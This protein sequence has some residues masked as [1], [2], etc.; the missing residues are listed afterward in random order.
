LIIAERLVPAV[1]RAWPLSLLLA[2]LLAVP[3]AALAAPYEGPGQS[4]IIPLGD[5]GH[6]ATL[7]PDAGL[8][9]THVA[10]DGLPADTCALDVGPPADGPAVAAHWSIGNRT[11]YVFAE[12]GARDAQFLIAAHWVWD[13]KGDC[14]VEHTPEGVI[15]HDPRGRP[16]IDLKFP[17]RRLTFTPTTGEWSRIEV[18]IVNNGTLPEH[19]D[20]TLGLRRAHWEIANATPAANVPIAPGATYVFG[21]DLLVPLEQ[22][23]RISLLLVDLAGRESGTADRATLVLD[24]QE[25]EKP[26]VVARPPPPALPPWEEPEEAP[27]SGVIALLVLVLGC[28]AVRRRVSG[29]APHRHGPGRAS[30]R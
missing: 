5:G 15:Y 20:I 28:L 11:A 8:G 25:G 1:L 23:A 27:G 3:P 10:L 19:A 13:V 14:T 2:T 18:P 17:E 29:S 9:I 4:G 30:S 24:L 7:H 6:L 26:P 22:P 16:F 21:F 12:P